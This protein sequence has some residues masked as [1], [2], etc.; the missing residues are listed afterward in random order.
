[1]KIKFFCATI[2]FFMPLVGLTQ[3]QDATPPGF[4]ISLKNGSMVRGRTLTRD[5][6]SGALRLTMTETGTGG[7]KSYAI[8]AMDDADSIRASTTDADSI[9]VKLFGG[10]ELRCKEFG[11]NGDT[12]TVKLGTASRIDVRWDQ[13]QSISFAP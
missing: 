5:E 9:L 3:A 7:P 10:S 4:T 6:A 8:I 13:I 1:M 2:L 11:L 12:V